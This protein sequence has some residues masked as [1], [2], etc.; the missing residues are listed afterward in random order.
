M[1]EQMA[2]A[3]DQSTAENASTPLPPSRPAAAAPSMTLKAPTRRSGGGRS[4]ASKLR[5]K[6]VSKSRYKTYAMYE[7]LKKYGWVKLPGDDLAKVEKLLKRSQEHWE[8]AEA[9]RKI[10]HQET[11][12]E[13]DEVRDILLLERIQDRDFLSAT[14]HEGTAQIMQNIKEH[15][16]SIKNL[17]RIEWNWEKR[18]EDWDP[19]VERAKQKNEQWRMEEEDTHIELYNLQEEVK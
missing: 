11:L 1:D 19:F 15:D 13:L 7:L 12:D 9:A 6:D 16:A 5:E 3:A 4:D 10:E 14:L 8:K 17:S 2:A 18:M